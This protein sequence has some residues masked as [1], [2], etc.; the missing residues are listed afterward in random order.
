MHGRREDSAWELS[1]GDLKKE[2]S[3]LAE[4]LK[5]QD[6]VTLTSTLGRVTH[7][8]LSL[9]H[10]VSSKHWDIIIRESLFKHLRDDN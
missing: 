4:W 3:Y 9:I 7:H 8:L 6:P 1:Y 2:N 5:N 10:F